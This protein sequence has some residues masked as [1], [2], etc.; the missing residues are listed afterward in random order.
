MT[1]AKDYTNAFR[2]IT[3]RNDAERD[4]VLGRVEDNSFIKTSKNETAAFNA[5]VDSVRG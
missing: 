2:G 4:A 5:M 1:K 3:Y